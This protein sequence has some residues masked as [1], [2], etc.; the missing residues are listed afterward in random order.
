MLPLGVH[1]LEMCSASNCCKF[2]LLVHVLHNF[3]NIGKQPVVTLLIPTKRIKRKP[4]NS[5]VSHNSLIRKTNKMTG[6]YYQ[7]TINTNIILSNT[8]RFRQMK[9]G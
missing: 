9:P 1:I 5:A 8:A 4:T 2:F 3:D 7:K 6:S